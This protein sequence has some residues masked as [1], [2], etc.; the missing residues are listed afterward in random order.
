MPRPAGTSPFAVR[1]GVRSFY[2]IRCLEYRVC[3]WQQEN[4]RDG[5]TICTVLC[6]LFLWMPCFGQVVLLGGQGIWYQ[7]PVHVQ[8]LASAAVRGVTK[9]HLRQDLKSRLDIEKDRW[10]Y[11]YVAINV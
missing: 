4:H 7:K 3:F 8:S 2:A 10:V 11:V 6:R 5:S 9:M 1:T